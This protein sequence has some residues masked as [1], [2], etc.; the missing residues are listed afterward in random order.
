MCP[1]NES[2]SPAFW[3]GSLSNQLTRPAE[4]YS[5]VIPRLAKGGHLFAAIARY[6]RISHG[7]VSS[8]SV[9][10]RVA[11]F[12]APQ[13]LAARTARVLYG[14]RALFPSS[15]RRNTLSKRPICSV[16]MLMA[17]SFVRAWQSERQPRLPQAVELRRRDIVACPPTSPLAPCVPSQA[18]GEVNMDLAVIPRPSR[19]RKRSL[20]WEVL[21]EAV[22]PSP[23]SGERAHEWRN[24]WRCCLV[25][26]RSADSA[27][28]A[29]TRTPQSAHAL[30]FDLGPARK[31][32]GVTFCKRVL[33]H[34]CRQ[35]G[36]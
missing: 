1:C 2:L 17:A 30:R 24:K 19:A 31:A 12:F 15:Y 33:E 6:G 23:A 7:E 20:C 13:R 28:S 27:P 5:D 22:A 32:G 34:P 35:L 29:A 18:G 9:V 11:R 3:T 4:N 36:C 14:L 25:G 21:S 10:V 26:D 16:T 8:P